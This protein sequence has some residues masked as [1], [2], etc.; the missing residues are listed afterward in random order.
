M[1]KGVAI[2]YDNQG[3]VELEAFIYGKWKTD[4][5]KALARYVFC[6]DISDD[7]RRTQIA[8]CIDEFG[9]RVQESVFEAVLDAKLYD[10]V[11]TRL[12][13]LLNEGEDRLTIYSLCGACE[14]RRVD[15]GI[16]ADGPHVG[17]ETVFIV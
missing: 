8:N 4:G 5:D 1:E 17:D 12:E 16:G 10:I 13:E 14:G 3:W 6:Y 9:D 11:K 2:G 7:R 15:M